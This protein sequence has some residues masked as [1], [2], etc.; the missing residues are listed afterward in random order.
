MLDRHH[1]PS[2][3]IYLTDHLEAVRR[4]LHFLQPSEETHEYFLQLEEALVSAG[5]D[6]VEIAAL[7]TPVALL[8]DIGK[9][10]ED[11]RAEGEHPLTGRKV[12]LRHPIVSLVAGLELLPGALAGRDTMLALI[13]EHGTPFAWY[14]QFKRTERVP[15]RK[16]WARLDQKIDAREDGTGLVLLSVFKLADIDGHENVEDVP[17]FVEQVNNNYLREKGKWLPVPDE[18]A[19]Q[20]LATSPSGES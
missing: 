10:R 5:L 1:D 11:K 7:L 3:D 15:K 18:A 14:T 20:S 17:W 6:P 4:N 2:E 12:K 19:I 9:T 8:H 13:E 16:S